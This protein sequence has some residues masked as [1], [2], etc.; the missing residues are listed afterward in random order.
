MHIFA[1]GK[2]ALAMAR[3]AVEQ[4][5]DLVA[6][7]L[8]V[9]PAQHVD[10]DISPLVRLTTSH[11]VPDLRSHDAGM[12]LLQTFSDLT[13]EETAIALISGGASSLAIA[14]AHG[15]SPQSLIQTYRTL[16][17]SGANIHEINCVRR[18][19][20][21]IKGGGLLRA[22][23][24]QVHTLAISDVVNDAPHD[25]GSGP[26]TID[27]TSFADA[28]NVVVKHRLADDLPVEIL[29]HLEC[30]G[31]VRNRRETL[32]ATD[33]VAKNSFKIV[34]SRM[35]ALR[36]LNT[37]LRNWGYKPKIENA[38]YSGRLESYTNTIIAAIKRSSEGD[39]ILFAGEPTLQVPSRTGEGGR[40]LHLALSLCQR[41]SGSPAR[42]VVFA[43]D[44]IDGCSK[45]SGAW[46]DGSTHTK[47]LAR[48]VDVQKSLA[49]FDAAS[50][51]VAINQCMATGP[52]GTNANDIVVVMMQRLE[53]R[54]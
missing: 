8:V 7:G 36:S 42:I 11:P 14:P 48:G 35:D 44:G 45:F 39:A 41:I 19:L 49:S 20:S 31:S 22:S 33:P 10:D 27:P 47:L 12:L 50:A 17:A 28:W 18:H 21:R 30:S 38:N 6:G 26:T 1:I 51:L 3:A 43:T 54:G 29:E 23:S 5:D 46:I 40:C 34:A 53:R 4:L 24:A 16:V 52:T 13:P 2:A 15:L 37:T 32:K 25:I 9:T